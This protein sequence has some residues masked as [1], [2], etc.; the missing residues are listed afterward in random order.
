[1]AEPRVG[2]EGNRKAASIPL[3]SESPEVQKWRF[4]ERY[5][6]RKLRWSEVEVNLSG[7]S[8]IEF[9]REVQDLARILYKRDHTYPYTLRTW[10]T[11]LAFRKVVAD[12]SEPLRI[13][14]NVD[15]S[16]RKSVAQQR[17]SE[18]NNVEKE[19][20]A[21][22]HGAFFI[23]TGKDLFDGSLV[24][25]RGKTLCFDELGLDEAF[26]DDGDGHPFVAASRLVEL[27]P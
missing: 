24:R 4:V 26:A 3:Q 13:D 1:M 27:K 20:L 25:C 15:G 7:V 19:D 21:V 2:V 10:G 12:G 6:I 22:A 18:L 23:L 5:A 17:E 8:R 16:K 14:G 11:Q 9:L